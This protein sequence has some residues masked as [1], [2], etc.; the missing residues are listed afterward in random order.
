MVTINLKKY[1]PEYYEE[2]TYVDV[3]DDVSE[4]LEE[5]RPKP[6][7]AKRKAQRYKAQYSLDAGD[8]IEEDMLVLLFE[9]AKRNELLY[10]RLRSA[11]K[12]LTAKQR[13]RFL[14]KYDL[15]YTYAEIAEKEKVNVNAIED[16]IEQAKE[17]IKNIFVKFP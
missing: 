10:E 13:R 7:S 2:D 16:S 17:K 5:N 6:A 3:E 9:E 14:M 1:Y 11:M 12:Y 15:E 4:F 8:G